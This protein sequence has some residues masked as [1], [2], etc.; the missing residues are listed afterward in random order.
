MYLDIILAK[1][2]NVIP[3][4]F[5]TIG[6]TCICIA[7]KAHEIMNPQIESYLSY[8]VNDDATDEMDAYQR[9]IGKRLV[10]KLMYFFN[11]VIIFVIADC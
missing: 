8:M 7:V 4:I 10:A 9:S 3:L 1:W 5:Q 2:T 6:V 11:T